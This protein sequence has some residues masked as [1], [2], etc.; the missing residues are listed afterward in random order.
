M[1]A[2]QIKAGAR[3]TPHHVA[4]DLRS[5]KTRES[6]I[7]ATRSV[8][9]LRVLSGV[10]RIVQSEPHDIAAVVLPAPSVHAGALGR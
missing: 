2:H 4:R 1:S 9:F 10:G 6:T 3:K 5:K 8:L 7:G